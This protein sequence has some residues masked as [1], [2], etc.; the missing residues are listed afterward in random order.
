MC[1]PII[2]LLL[3]FATLTACQRMS[4][5]SAAPHNIHLDVQTPVV[6]QPGQFRAEAQVQNLTGAPLQVNTYI[7]SIASLSLEIRD[8]RGNPVYHLP[9]P[10]PDTAQIAAGRMTLEPGAAV[11]VQL[12]DLSV[13]ESAFPPGDYQVRMVGQGSSADAVVR[14]ESAWVDLRHAAN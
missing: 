1:R 2:R 13:A 5:D 14:L 7:L 9:P 4:P 11:T 3:A 12:R 8:A 6:Q 10:S